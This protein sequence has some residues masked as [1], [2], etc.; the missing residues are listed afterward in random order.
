LAD[1][2]IL[3]TIQVISHGASLHPGARKRRALLAV[4]LP[5]ADQTVSTDRVIDL[6]LGDR[7]PRSV[8]C[9]VQI[10]V[11]ESRRIFSEA[12]LLGSFDVFGTDTVVDVR[13][14]A[15]RFRG[16]AGGSW[17]RARPGGS[18]CG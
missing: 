10:H 6:I 18:G 1:Y 8:A 16:G 11:S 13:V 9:S 14:E 2:G 4:L 17:H 5:N 12:R 15:H 3:A 7:A